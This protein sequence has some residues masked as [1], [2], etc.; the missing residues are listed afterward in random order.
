L[1]VLLVATSLSPDYGGP[2]FSVSRLAE[3]LTEAGV[4]VGLWASDQS[5]ITTPLLP[6]GSTVRRLRGSVVEALEQFG[7]PDVFHDNG[8]WLWHN[9]RVARLAARLGVPR[10]VSARGMLE[11]W[12]MKNKKWKKVTAWR[13]YQRRDL[14]KARRLH[15]TAEAEARNIRRLGLGVPICTIP[16]GVDVPEAVPSGSR[17]GPKTALFLGRVHPKK[18]LP[19]LVEAWA[20]VR[21]EG[22]RLKIVGPDEGGHRAQVEQTV[23]A[24]GLG[25]VVSFTGPLDGEEKAAAFFDADFF[26]LPTY[27]E[28]FGIAIAEALAHGLPVLTTTGAPWPMLH[29]RGCGWVVEPGVDEIAGALRQ[30]TSCTSSALR[31]MGANG[32]EF[33]NAEFGWEGIARQFVATYEE[34]LASQR[35]LP[36]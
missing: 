18:G 7:A 29:E 25:T 21:P 15:A 23:A 35:R 6:A 9:H 20:R 12:S 8:M 34:M 5:A 1:R 28:N 17:A 24:A 19:M 11:P 33:V 13:L 14:M 27:S 30:A 10:V 26:V 32:R 31:A 4:E 2:A 16:N 22:W 36:R 3:A